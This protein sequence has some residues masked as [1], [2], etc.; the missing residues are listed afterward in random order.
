MAL[1]NMDV[2]AF[3]IKL[4]LM[5]LNTEQRSLTRKCPSAFNSRSEQREEGKLPSLVK[6]DGVKSSSLQRDHDH[7]AIVIAPT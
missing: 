3:I 1:A 7:I 5:Y 6:P 4:F 2:L